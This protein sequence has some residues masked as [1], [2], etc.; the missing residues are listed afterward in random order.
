METIYTLRRERA[1]HVAP[2]LLFDLN[3]A[4]QRMEWQFAFFSTNLHNLLPSLPRREYIPTFRRLHASLALSF[5]D[6]EHATCPDFMQ[7]QGWDNAWAATL[8]E[9]PGIICTFHTGAYRHLNYVLMQMGVPISIVMAGRA[10]RGEQRLL[11]KLAVRMAESGQDQK[12]DVEF[13][14]AELP[15]ALFRMAKAA[16]HGRSLLVY[17][18]GN[19]GAQGSA[20]ADAARNLLA[21]PFCGW[22]MNVRQGVAALAY[23]LQVP[24]YP[25]IC[26]RELGWGL[27][28][29]HRLTYWHFNRICPLPDEPQAAFA[30]RATKRLYGLL[31]QFVAQKP[32]QWEG[33]L[34]LQHHLVTPA[35]TELDEE[36]NPIRWA[37]FRWGKKAFLLHR[38][39]YMSYRVSWKEFY[40][41]YPWYN[42]DFLEI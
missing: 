2:Y 42:M 25:I 35:P 38:P 20:T 17:I 12:P 8:H 14:D 26:E 4:T 5:M 40:Q 6:I 29:S 39:T 32:D 1:E 7:I 11:D 22:Q 27:H 10:I 13:I 23:R 34:N 31:E 28:L 21:I 9:R 16:K 30:A 24:L 18:D 36:E 3:H 33:W 15:H 41:K 37:P 19:T